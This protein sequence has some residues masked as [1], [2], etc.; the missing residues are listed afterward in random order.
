MS[1]AKL[2]NDNMLRFGLPEFTPAVN[3]IGMVGIG[4]L[5]KT[6]DAQESEVEANSDLNLSFAGVASA[7]SRQVTRLQTGFRIRVVIVQRTERIAQP[8]VQAGRS[9]VEQVDKV[10]ERQQAPAFVEEFDRPVKAQ[11][12]CEQV[13]PGVGC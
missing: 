13:V 8:A 4:P 3:L 1:T 2:P 10:H 11:V 9:V 7:R 5:R 12:R 6:K